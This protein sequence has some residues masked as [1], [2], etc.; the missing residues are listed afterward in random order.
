VSF[1]AV[2]AFFLYFCAGILIGFFISKA[3]KATLAD[4]GPAFQEQ[5]QKTEYMRLC[6]DEGISAYS[7]LNNW[8]GVQS[9]A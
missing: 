5:V 8:M 9:N 2:W 3:L 6:A 1:K 7:C 4:D